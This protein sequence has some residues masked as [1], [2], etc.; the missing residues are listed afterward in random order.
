MGTYMIYDT[1]CFTEYWLPISI[2]GSEIAFDGFEV[3]FR[4]D[5]VGQPEGGA[6]AYIKDPLCG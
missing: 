1:L 5:R 4:N 2:P 6:I 3:I